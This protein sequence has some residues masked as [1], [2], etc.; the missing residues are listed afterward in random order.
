VICLLETDQAAPSRILQWDNA[1][2]LRNAS[3]SRRS[4]YCV[5][6][7]EARGSVDGEVGRWSCSEWREVGSHFEQV[8]EV[9]LQS[10]GVRVEGHDGIS[11]ASTI[12]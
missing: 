8:A 10:L 4:K 6:D 11:D 3:E 5:H 1:G 9:G 7:F 12:R 2:C